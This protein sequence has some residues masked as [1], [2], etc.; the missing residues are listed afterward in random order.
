M[1]EKVLGILEKIQE[2]MGTMQTQINE[3]QTKMT[4]LEKEVHE[5]K[6]VTIRNCYDLT[7]LKRTNAK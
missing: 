3:I 6:Q 5:I 7:L 4:C 1:E 2:Q